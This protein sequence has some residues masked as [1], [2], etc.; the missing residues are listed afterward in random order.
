VAAARLVFALAA[1]PNDDTRRV[2]AWVK[3]NIA[4]KADSL[5]FR[6]PDGRMEWEH[7]P[8]ALDAETLLRPATPQEREE[9]GDAET[10]LREL[11]ADGPQRSTEIIKAAEANGISRRQLYAAKSRL[12]ID[13]TRVGGVASGGHWIWSLTV[14][15]KSPTPTGDHLRDLR[16]LRPLSVSRESKSINSLALEKPGTHSGVSAGEDDSER[17]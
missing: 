17:F 2:L 7:A 8:V 15:S 1:D 3:G 16:D 9:R 14:S 13:A 12:N 4:K 6:L 5:A 10:L 11:L